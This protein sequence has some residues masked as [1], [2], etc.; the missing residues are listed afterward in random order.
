MGLSVTLTIALAMGG[1]LSPAAGLDITPE[2]S[3]ADSKS[4]ERLDFRKK[5]TKMM[6]NERRPGAPP[7][8]VVNAL[9]DLEPLMRFAKTKYLRSS[10]TESYGGRKAAMPSGVKVGQVPA[11][12]YW[13]NSMA[14]R[15]YAGSEMKDIPGQRA[16]HSWHYEDNIPVKTFFK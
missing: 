9:K 10:L 4:V 5:S 16:W 14:W 7:V 6:L 15:G 11:F 1:S 3:W 12:S 2:S 13:D 8:V